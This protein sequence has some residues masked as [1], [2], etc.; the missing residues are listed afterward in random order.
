MIRQSFNEGWKV[1]FKQHLFEAVISPASQVDVV[2]PYDA[3]RDL[4]RDPDSANGSHSGYFPSAHVVYEKSFEA[5]AEW[6]QRTVLL[7]FE[8]VYRDAMVYLNGN[9]VAQRPSGY[10]PFVAHLDPYLEFG[11]VNR[12]RVESRAHQDSRWYTGV[13]VYRNVWLVVG[14]PFHIPLD[15]TVITTPEV[16]EHLATVTAAVTVFNG[17]R[18]TRVATLLTRVFDPN[19]VA[20]STRTVPVT[21]PPGDSAWMRTR[22]WVRDPQLWDVDSPLLYRVETTLSDSDGQTVDFEATRFGI[23]TIRLDPVHGLRLNGQTVKL[24]GGCIHHDNG[25]LGAAAIDR[26]EHR[27]AELIRAAGFNAV[28]SAH[29]GTSRAFLDACDRVGLL[30]M[31]EF[32]DVWTEA[33]TSFDTALTFAD[34]WKRDL[35][36]WI[37]SAR[38][39]PSLLMYSIGNEILEIGRPGAAVW[40]RRLAEEVRA[41]DPTRPVTNAVNSLVSVLDG[42]VNR[43]GDLPSDFNSLLSAEG[44][45]TIGSS[46]TATRLTE[47]AHA[48]VDVA[49]I[50]YAESRYDLDA[51]LFPD[52]I[53]VGTESFPGWLDQ[54]WAL[55]EKHPQVIGD[56]A[57]T[58]WDHL[59][60]AG[61]GRAYYDDDPLRPRGMASPYPWLVSHAGTIDINGIRQPISYWRE[62]VWGIRTEP[63]IA[64]HRPQRFGQNLTRTRWSWDDVLSSWA[65]DVP[66]GSP[67]TVDVYSDAEEVE[68]LLNG[69]S[70]GTAAVGIDD[71]GIPR[72]CIA[73]F[74]IQFVPGELVAIARRRGAE[75]GRTALH[76]LHGATKLRARAEAVR[77]IATPSELAYVH[78]E[79][80]D[81]AGTLAIDRS[82]LVRVTVEGPAT[83]AALSSAKPDDDM[84]FGGDVHRTFEG[85]LLAIIRPTGAGEVQVRAV[86][87]R[88]GS[89]SVSLQVEFRDDQRGERE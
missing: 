8:G 18:H 61:T 71:K 39:H 58:A 32:A 40:G 3:M 81:D 53:I 37:G 12:I 30:V 17:T 57:W 82:D 15:T 49:G 4:V 6:A 21:V 73:R 60:E 77:L 65:W 48:Q 63:Y 64:V 45:S 80:C 46:E 54:L 69:H 41:L 56:F 78:L 83:L 9:L 26:A 88:W 62:V 11:A 74:E 43:Q 34:W 79:L 51:T 16:D 86:G 14:D 29:N 70:I 25:P 38:N 7:E 66:T 28:R 89:A 55:V 13:G 22:H 87:E 5:P 19:G 10:S 50:N 35:A 33:K 52:R 75:T 23:R 68:L 1:A 27:K 59:G 85:R 67:V 47:E 2:L 24:R 76:S 42:A 36:A 20:V 72:G 44:T 84:A 31:D